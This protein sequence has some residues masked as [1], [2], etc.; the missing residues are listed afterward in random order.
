M[1]LCIRLR[2]SFYILMRNLWYEL[3]FGE[4]SQTETA[5]EQPYL[6]LKF[7]LFHVY[8]S[9]FDFVGHMF[10]VSCLGKSFATWSENSYFSDLVCG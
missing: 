3:S 6:E 9:T 8:R 2:Y 5:V 4:D 10:A 7:A 1:V